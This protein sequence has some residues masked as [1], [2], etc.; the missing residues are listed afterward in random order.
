MATV[1][2][3]NPAD[4]ASR[5]QSFY[6]PKLLDALK[7][8][9]AIAQYGLQGKYPAAGSTPTVRFFRPRAANTTG[10]AA[11][12]EGVT[13]ATLSEVAVG[14]VDVPLTQRGA[15]AKITDLVLATDLLDTVKLYTQTMGADAA[16]DLDTVCR[17]ALVTALNDSN[18]VYGAGVYFERFAGTANT[19]ASSTDFA[20]FHALSAANAKMTRAENLKAITQLK[21][22]KVP[23]ING[24]FVAVTPPEVIHDLRQ[25]TTVTNAMTNVD[26]DK[27]YKNAQVM[28][29]GV[30]FVEAHNPFREGATYKTFS[31]TGVNFSTIYL[32]DAA[33]GVPGMDNPKAGGSPMSP[34]LILIN[35]PD[36]ANPLGLYVQLGWKAMYGAKALITNVAGEVP[37]H[38]LLRTKSTFA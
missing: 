2:L 30:V 1:T 35:K 5:V 14:Y 31:A 18:A 27:L 24:R 34:Q 38:L 37:H 29:D 17:N 3:A 10:V 12:G 4:F 26:S 32:G 13:P 7:F 33:F 22:A 25:D 36:H 11:I 16:L 21:A 19:G 28:L 15:L 9:L 6:N 20:T 23:K 8:N